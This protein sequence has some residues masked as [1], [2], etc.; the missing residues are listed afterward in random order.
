M[1][2]I[3][4]NA[5][6]WSSQCW[7]HDT[8]S[9]GTEIIWESTANGVGNF[10]HEQWKQAEKGLSEFMPIFVPWYWQTEYRKKI[11]DDFIL[12]DEELK[13]TKQYNLDLGQMCW[14][15]KKIAELTTDGTDGIKAF[16]Q[17][18]PMNAAEAFQ[19]SGGDGLITAERSPI[20]RRVTNF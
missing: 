1:K 15:R 8:D 6:T 18:Y 16:K 9:D 12:N 10:F 14:R 4:S 5:G 3:F 11:T 7:S 2:S 19:F 20:C 17:E 13:I